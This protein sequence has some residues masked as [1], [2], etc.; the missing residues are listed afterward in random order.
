MGQRRNLPPIEWTENG[1]PALPSRLP[2]P[3][4]RPPRTVIFTADDFGLSAA[5]NGA[6]ALAHRRGLLRCASL[7]AAGPHFLEAVRLA[8]ELPDLCLGVHLTLIQGRAVLPPAE[9]PHLVD[10]RGRF[11]HDPVKTGWRYFWEPGLLPEINRELRAQIEAVLEAGI[12]PWHLNSHLN[13][14]LHPKIFPLVLD[15]AREY[16]I[17]AVRLA[18]ED[19][20]TTLALA[21]DGPL[22]KIAQGIIFTLLC[23]R[24]ARLAR[25]AGLIYNDRLFGLLNDGRMTETYLLGLVPRLMPGV[26][27]IYCHPGLY[28][29]AEL[30]YWAPAYRRQAELAALL[31]PRLR[32]AL[33]AAGIELSDFRAL[34][35]KLGN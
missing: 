5:L 22:P 28:A 31:S 21:P 12:T 1:G 32:D 11:L 16:R 17:P 23:R 10:S 33:A 9:L 27:E 24:A 6:V 14:H 15:L 13:L 20:R 19:W 34:S 30:Q 35:H 4:S 8:R 18:R 3:V 26:T 7:M 2:S 29:D 25:A